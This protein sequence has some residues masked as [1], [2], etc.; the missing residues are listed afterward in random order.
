MRILLFLRQLEQICDS[1]GEPKRLTMW[2]QPFIVAKFCVASMTT[3][4]TFANSDYALSLVFKGAKGQEQNYTCVKAANYRLKLFAIDCK[5]A[6][7]AAEINLF[8]D[9]VNGTAA[10]MGK[11]LNNRA[12]ECGD[13]FFKRHTKSI[14]VKELPQ[15]V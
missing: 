13:D 15:R 8:S 2:L 6:K 4:S 5:V 10:E 9:Y 11:A 1:D 14:I 3:R 7:P 12:S